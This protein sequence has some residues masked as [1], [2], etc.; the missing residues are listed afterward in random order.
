MNMDY[1]RHAHLRVSDLIAT[2]SR[3]NARAFRMPALVCQD[4]GKI[5]ITDSVQYINHILLALETLEERV[6]AIERASE[7]DRDAGYR[8]AA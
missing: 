8:I 2:T 1:C 5:L 4:C 3:L 7:S 6:S